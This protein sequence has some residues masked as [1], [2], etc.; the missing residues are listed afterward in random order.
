MNPRFYDLK[1]Q[2]PKVAREQDRGLL[3][4]MVRNGL[5]AKEAEVTRGLIHAV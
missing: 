4:P 5:A 2:S 3:R 1:G